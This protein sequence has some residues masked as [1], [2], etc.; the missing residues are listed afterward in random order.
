MDERAL[1]EQKDCPPLVSTQE[2][3][4]L[5]GWDYA[6]NRTMINTLI[7]RGKFPQPIQ[8]L[9]SGPVWTQKQILDYKDS[10]S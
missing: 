5:L 6:K 7:K 1:Q 10:R 3:F 8:R 9:A 4:I 2:A